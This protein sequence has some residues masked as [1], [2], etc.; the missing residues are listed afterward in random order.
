MQNPDNLRVAA[1]A[2]ELANAIYDYTRRFPREEIFGLTAQMRRAAI[3]VGSNIFEACGRQGHREN[4][5]N[6]SPRSFFYNSHGSATELVFQLR[7]A[8]RQ[9]MG[10]PKEAAA[11]DK[12]LDTIRRHLRRLI[13]HL[14]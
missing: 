4:E 10:H 11:I 3:S 12:Q 1:E 5:S 2:E 6:A 9:R 14:P 7:I 13:I 8:R